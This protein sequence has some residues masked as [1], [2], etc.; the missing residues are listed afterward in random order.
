MNYWLDL[1]S[2]ETYEAYSKSDRT[3]SGFRI[4]QRNQAE[5]ISRGDRFVCYMTKLSRWVGIL[6]IEDG[7]FIDD[8]PLFYEEDDPFVVRFRVKPVVWLPKEKAVPIHD[9]QVWDRLTFTQGQD[10]RSSTWTGKIRASRAW[11]CIDSRM[12]SG[13]CTCGS[14][15]SATSSG[16]VTDTTRSSRLTRCMTK[17]RYCPS[18]T[19]YTCPSAAAWVW[20]RSSRNCPSAVDS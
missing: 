10:K 16:T 1:F 4:R 17:R 14:S 19:S 8:T 5:K 11:I 6:E 13:G 12:S 3:I 9:D 20:R 18:S 2:P 7:P 15:S